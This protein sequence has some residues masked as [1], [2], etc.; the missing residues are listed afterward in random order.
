[1][2]R[3]DALAALLLG[4]AALALYLASLCRTVFLGD[5]GELSAAIASG[6]VAHP[7]GYPLFT[8]LGTLA[9]RLVPFGE[10]AFR[11]G[12][13]VALSAALTVVLLFRLARALDAGL[14]ASVCVAA[15]FGLGRT[16]W[17]QAARVEVYSLH[18]LLLA[19][20]LVASLAFRRD[21]RP[22]DLAAA[23]LCVG[24]GAAH[25]LTL[26]LSVPGLLVLVGPRLWP[27]R[28]RGL[29]PLL[30][31]GVGPCLYAE[32]VRRA[33]A[34]PP[35]NWGRVV[36]A[37]ALFRHVAGRA[38]QSY[39]GPPTAAG[40]ALLARLVVENLP[41]PLLL[42]AAAGVWLLARR[43]RALAFGL[44]LTGLIPFAFA[45]CYGIED[46]APYTLGPL[47]VA[48]AFAAVGAGAVL[49]SVPPVA[50]RPLMVLLCA[51]LPALWAGNRPHADLSGIVAAR[52]LARAKLRSCPERAVLIVTG[53]ND[54]FPILYVQNALGERRDVLVIARDALRFS[55]R[56]L[57][58]EPS[59]WYVHALRRQGLPVPTDLPGAAEIRRRAEDGCLIDL[60]EGPL[61]DRP[62][63]TTFLALPESGPDDPRR[64]LTWFAARAS[65]PAGVVVRLD[66]ADRPPRVV[67]VVAAN[68]AFWDATE[69]P[70]L[71]AIRGRDEVTPDY[72]AR[73]YAVMLGWHAR[74]L[75]TIL[76][77]EARS[78]RERIRRWAPDLADQ[79]DAERASR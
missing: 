70:E 33:A 68:R 27:P 3:R 63:R 37:D 20:A 46:I 56:N 64:V 65:S 67:D 49:D 25:H 40:A 50:A 36:S 55:W 62:L 6:G 66:P 5:S 16:F 18:T 1:M 19:G 12:C 26:V 21:G 78:V 79:L 9:L 44:G 29:A 4:V 71:G 48:S 47:L 52:E 34:D 53:D 69:L 22:R 11:I 14:V 2:P 38:Y 74:V 51:L 73:H 28:P 54:L 45:L 60:L 8:L 43:D 76:P 61:R 39:L 23:A 17:S 24:L 57:P 75:E 59:L 41:V 58:G 10:P 15:A 31:A 42:A 13:L 30:A 35:M 72:V 32:L 7:P 77:L